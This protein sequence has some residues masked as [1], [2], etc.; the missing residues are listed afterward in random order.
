MTVEVGDR[1]AER[2]FFLWKSDP[3]AQFVRVENL[4]PHQGKITLALARNSIYTLTTTQGQRKG[5]PRLLHPRPAAFPFLT[6]TIS[7][8]R[9]G[10]PA[11]VFTQDQAGVFE[12]QPW[13]RGKALKQAVPAMGIEWHFHLNSEPVT[14]IGDPQMTDYEVAIDVRLDAPQS[15]SVYGRI[16]KVVQHQIQPPMSYWLRVEADGDGPSAR[17]EDL[18]LLDRI[19]ID[20]PGRP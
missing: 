15:A 4:K 9:A 13:G 5:D 1:F 2:E 17:T 20:N 16:A 14:I 6:S 18:L 19:D 8:P 10:I 3:E 7:K 12:V 11:R